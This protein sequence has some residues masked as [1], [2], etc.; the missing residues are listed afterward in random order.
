[1]RASNSFNNNFA[2]RIFFLKL[3]N[4]FDDELFVPASKTGKLAHYYIDHYDG[5]E[6][7]DYKNNKC[8]I[9]SGGGCLLK[10]TDFTLSMSAEFT[11]FLQNISEG[12]SE[13]VNV[14]NNVF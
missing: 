14:I 11:K 12:F 3:F 10:A 6:V 1:M 13:D 2:F 4:F 9:E 8:Y 5:F 7:R